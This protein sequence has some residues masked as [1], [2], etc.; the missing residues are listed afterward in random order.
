MAAVNPGTYRVRVVQ[1]LVNEIPH[2]ATAQIIDS[3]QG[4]RGHLAEF[5]VQRMMTNLLS[6]HLPSPELVDWN[7]ALQ[8]PALSAKFIPDIQIKDVHR[9]LWAAYEV[10]TLFRGGEL[11]LEVALADL[12]KLVT[13]KTHYP[14]LACF[15]WLV[16]DS[17]MLSDKRRARHW[18]QTALAYDVNSFAQRAAPRIIDD[19]VE[20]KYVARP[21][22]ASVD[23]HVSCYAWEILR[24]DDL[25]SE[26][27]GD[28][29]F[30]ASMSAH[31]SATKPT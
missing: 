11:D 3:A 5:E 9:E 1:L 28:F 24:L 4:L 22:M 31:Y 27:H 16:A 19:T 14:R 12:E 20:T 10:K 25:A 13:Y 30:E 17:Q 15:F 23:G 26:L 7:V 18:A 8:H 29:H 2:R 21:A 6:L